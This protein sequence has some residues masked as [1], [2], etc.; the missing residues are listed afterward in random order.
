MATTP[1]NYSI[2]SPYYSTPTFDSGKFLDIMNYRAIPKLA[3]DM[4]SA[5]P[6]Q[7]DLRPDLF[8][9]DL[10]GNPGLW[11]VFAARNP[12]TLFDPL[13]DFTAGTVIY[14]P[15]KSTL[16]TALGT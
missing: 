14:L 2:T 15:Q 6:A 5:I 3:N 12:N 9:Y 7:Y 10:Y 4:L 1:T 13:W 11:W 8:A 16:Q